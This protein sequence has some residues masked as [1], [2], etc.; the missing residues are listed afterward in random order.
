MRLGASV[1]LGTMVFTSGCQQAGGRDVR[2]DPKNPVSIEIWHY[3]NG[4]QKNAFDEMISEFNDTVGLE[5]GIIVEACS[6]G[7][8]SEL[9]EKVIDA[10]NKK[11][12]AGDIP[13]VFA[14]YADTALQV[15]KLGPVSYTHLDVYKR[16]HF[17]SSTRKIFCMIRAR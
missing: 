6:Q 2:L 13:D 4:P 8:V 5:E 3:Y 15:D 11:V 7:N 12:G 16:Q 14:A 17:Y 1:L 9:T 10:A